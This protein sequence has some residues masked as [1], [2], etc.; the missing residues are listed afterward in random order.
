MP[1]SLNASLNV[2]LNPQSLNAST[3][4]VQQALGRITGQASEFQKSLDASTA[5]VFAFGATTAVLNSVTQSFKKLV[6]TTIEVE[7]KLVEI[8][9]IF[10]ATDVQFN[11]FRNS[12]FAVAKETG[13]A[14]GTVADGAA[15]LARQG[16]SAEE[17]AKRLKASLVLTRI[18]GLD[19]EKSVKALTA[20]INGFAS[21]GLSAN[22]IVNKLVAV[23]TAFAV[24]AQDLAEAFSRA[25]STAEDAGV[26]FDQ[27]LGLV[28]AVEQKTARGGAVIGNAFKSIFTRLQRGTTI[29]ELKELGVAIDASQTGIQKL[30]ALSKAIEGISDP[31]VV[32]K[33]K[34][35]AGGVFQINVVSAALKDLSSET[36][37][38]KGAAQTA[39][40]ATNEAFEKNA[41]LNKTI[42][43]QINSLVQG[44]T[45]LS[46]KIGS[47]TFGPVV[48]GLVGIASKIT[49][50]LDSALD[51][52]KGNVFVK[53]L[54]KTIGSFLS[55]PAI[56]IFTGAFIKIFKL[57]AKFA[58]DGLKSLFTIGTQS[59][60]IKNI[61]TGIV[62]LLQRDGNLRK[63]I[64]STTASQAQKEQAVI[65]AIQRENALLQTQAT[66]M[67]SLAAAAASRGVS[68]V[69]AS[70][71]FTRG[72]RGRAFATGFLEEEATARMLGAPPNV[73]A[74][75]G[76]GR[77]N[78]QRFVMNNAEMEIP[79]FAG[80]N[81]AV[82]PMYAGGNLPRYAIG[83]MLGKNP[84]QISQMSGSALKGFMGTKKFAGIGRG[85]A[86]S[87]RD[88]KAAA[89]RRQR[90]LKGQDM[91][92]VAVVNPQ[93]SAMLVPSI[94]FSGSI[95]AGTRGRFKFRGKPMGFE[96]GK[97]LGVF[98]P[99]VPKAVDQAADPQDERL[100]KNVTDSI[101]KSAA[102]Y[103]GLLRP[104]LGK[105]KPSE[106]RRMLQRQG[107]GKGALRG[108]VGAAFEAAVNVGLG[109]SPARKVDGGDFDIKR[110]SAEKRADTV[111]LFGVTPK[112]ANIFDYKENAGANSV[113]SFAKKLANDKKFTIQ[114]R[115]RLTA[116]KKGFAGGFMPKF[117]K[118]ATS[119]SG[120]GSGSGGGAGIGLFMGI[121]LLQ[122]ALNTFTSS[123]EQSDNV[124]QDESES[125]IQ[126][127]KERAAIDKTSFSALQ[128]NIKSIERKTEQEKRGADAIVKLADGANKA[129]IALS[130]FATLNMLTGGKVGG[131]A[132]NLIAGKGNLK[133]LSAA[134]RAGAM[135]GKKGIGGK[136]ARNKLLMQ[137]GGKL[138]GR[139][140]VAGTL[141]VGAFQIGSALLDKDLE[142][143]QKSGRIKESAT[144]M[145]GAAAGALIGQA[146]IPIPIVGALIGGAI[147][148]FAGDKVFQGSAD[149]ADIEVDNRKIES[150][151]KAREEGSLGMSVGDF[152]R[153]VVENLNK[154]AAAEG[155]EQAQGLLDRYNKALQNRADQIDAQAKG[156]TV[157]L[158]KIKDAQKALI[159]AAKAASGEMFSSAEAERKYNARVNPLKEQIFR[160]NLELQRATS[161]LA[162]GRKDMVQITADQLSK[163]TMRSQL[164]DFATG[165][166]GDAVRA[167]SE[168]KAMLA[169]VNVAKQARADAQLE[170]D[171]AE[172]RGADEGELEKLQQ[173]INKAGDNL[174]AKVEN[175]AV[176]FANRVVK[177][178]D[179]MEKNRKRIAEIRTGNT[180][181]TLS[182]ISAIAKGERGTNISNIM[183]SVEA[184]RSAIGGAENKR[185]ARGSEDFTEEEALGIA[186]ELEKV[187]A[188]LAEGGFDKVNV[189][190]G[191]RVLDEGLAEVLQGI[192]QTIERSL[193]GT[194]SSRDII[195]SQAGGGAITELQNLQ[196]GRDTESIDQLEEAQKNLG[197][198][199]REAKSNFA[200][201][202]KMFKGDEDAGNVTTIVLEL[203]KELQTASKGLATFKNFSTNIT[204]TIKDTNTLIDTQQQFVGRQET[205]INNIE[206]KISDL[207]ARMALVEK[208]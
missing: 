97:K 92:D 177:A 30:N 77:I 124:I 134:K 91:E 45:S 133:K 73:Q 118:G 84:A 117:A 23:D 189:L 96:Y 181:G 167:A 142:G 31:T 79:N 153:S 164:G 74:H 33:I 61:E 203:T 14:F 9:S 137:G 152:N 102:N 39:A 93:N 67:R 51:P 19:A 7:K 179:E 168:Q 75:F 184:L 202:N 150:K 20:A 105:P 59:E 121:G 52:E 126:S 103:A 86:Q 176:N 60:R 122:G 200:N 82:I 127:L 174:K 44:L 125:R 46:E 48:E 36:S 94:G 89:L 157:G 5:R 110:V 43:A 2:S 11:K 196:S 8:N 173:D 145:G 183:P 15:E 40:N 140:G 78:G 156:E 10:Q 18:S 81:S 148:A 180:K 1:T 163:A 111:K 195:G 27:L 143:K 208:E 170:F 83:G 107:G 158:K 138:A 50:A 90:S 171:R 201:L 87:D 21:A 147:G 63:Q 99:K 69:S 115:R 58:G 38:F 144:T 66:L 120:S 194:Q 34:E 193:I 146:A 114:P 3:K 151:T 197:A 160:A 80:G 25:G 119:K 85:S 139:L 37:I 95:P 113:A 169:D 56:V 204:D 12:I 16:L 47:I 62:G 108:A 129:F 128:N 100:R 182:E 57:V 154:V 136:A 54:F 116:G 149:M 175:A 186:R 98:G 64:A 49:E 185:K 123:V 72:R 28:T 132:G 53:G 206:G 207:E 198:E 165:P 155:N 159:D 178:S 166:M 13:Q 24:S 4:Q 187:K 190:D 68:G 71:V 26:S 112:S 70:G 188:A 104:L 106:I 192:D 161:D 101:S 88:A 205:M 17:T 199:M 141:G 6:S 29:E 131:F 162:N 65:Q 172:R 42:S 109:I 191:L 55:G 76:K 22:Q 35:L 41:A 32:S 135:S 130:A